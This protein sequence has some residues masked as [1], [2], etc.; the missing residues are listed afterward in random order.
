MKI[1]P[2]TVLKGEGFAMSLG[3]DEN[4]KVGSSLNECLWL[5]KKTRTGYIYT[6]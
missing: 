4:I 2:F 6:P 3:L 1:E 5:Y